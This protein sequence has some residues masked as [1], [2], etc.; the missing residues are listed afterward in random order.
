L[1]ASLQDFLRGIAR[2]ALAI[3]LPSLEERGLAFEKPV[4]LALEHTCALGNPVLD[5]LV[6]YDGKT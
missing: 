2:Q 3:D 5:E 1:T 6:V 4:H